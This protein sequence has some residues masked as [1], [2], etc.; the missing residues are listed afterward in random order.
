MVEDGRA[1]YR[2]LTPLA[3]ADGQAV[4]VDRGWVPKAFGAD[5]VL[6]D[7]RVDNRPRTITGRLDR[8]PR[9]G[10]A[11]ATTPED[12]DAGWPRVV[13]FPS[14]DELSAA[15]G[16]DLVNGVVLLDADAPDGFVRNWRPSDFGPERHLGYAVQWFALAGTLV[17]AYLAWSFRRSD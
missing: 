13:Q 8:L 2:V 4:I 1:G 5:A 14:A 7:V 10:I 3:L 9:P 12:K 11:L 16:M 15:L 6:P 17:V